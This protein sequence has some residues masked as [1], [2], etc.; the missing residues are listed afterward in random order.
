MKTVTV[1]QVAASKIL[2]TGRFFQNATEDAIALTLWTLG[3]AEGPEP[4]L[5][6]KDSTITSL[7]K[8]LRAD[9]DKERFGFFGDEN[10]V[11]GLGLRTLVLAI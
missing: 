11:L 8:K 4:E 1:F 2:A 6:S 5:E 9:L 3:R 10:K 7:R